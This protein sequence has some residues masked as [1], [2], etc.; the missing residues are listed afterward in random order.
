M[1]K[2]YITIIVLVLVVLG[3]LFF[4]GKSNKLETPALSDNAT[5]PAANTTGEVE[6]FTISGSNFSFKPVAIVVKKGTRV[7]IN[8]KNIE[9]THNLVIDEFKVATKTIKGGEAESVEFTADKIGSFEYYCSVGTHRAMGMWG[10]LIV[11]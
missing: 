2:T 5:V 10:T 1:K 7:R 8:F 11:E 6:Q 4:S 9:G 3:V